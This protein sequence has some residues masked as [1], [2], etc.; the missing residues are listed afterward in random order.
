MACRCCGQVVEFPDAAGPLE[1]GYDEEWLAVLRST[2][3]LLSLRPAPAALP[4]ALV[5]A[6]ACVSWVA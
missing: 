4:G 1:F 3:A 2:H 6:R 5:R